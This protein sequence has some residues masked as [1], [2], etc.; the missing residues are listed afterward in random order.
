MISF[1]TTLCAVSIMPVSAAS[2][3]QFFEFQLALARP[4]QLP[5]APAT[6][7]RTATRNVLDASAVAAAQQGDRRGSV[8]SSGPI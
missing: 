1:S 3:I 6:G 8:G 4:A 5:D 2:V 7:M